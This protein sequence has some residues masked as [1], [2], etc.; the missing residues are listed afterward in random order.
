MA[1]DSIKKLIIEEI[2][3]DSV[4]LNES[5]EVIPHEDLEIPLAETAEA[6]ERLW[7]LLDGWEGRRD[8]LP[9]RNEAVGWSDV[10]R[11][12]A[13]ISECD[14]ACFDEV[15]DGRKLSEQVQRESRGPSSS[16]S[17][18]RF[19]QD[20]LKQ[21]I[22][23]VKWLNELYGYLI[24]NELSEAINRYC[25]VPS[26]R[27]FLRTLPNLHRDEDIDRE[28]KD[29][30][31]LIGESKIRCEL[32]DTTLTFLSD[33]PGKG[34]WDNEYVVGELIKRL[35]E[36]ADENPEEK[37]AKASVRL[38]AWIAGQQNW[39]LLRDFPVFSEEWD[40]KNKRTF[41]LERLPENEVRLLAPSKAWA[42]PLQPFS[43]LFPQRHILANDFFE[44][45]PS[46]EV[47][48][49]LDRE[50]F[51]KKNVII[52]KEI[53]LEEFLPNEPL[54]VDDDHQTSEDVIVTDVVFRTGDDGI[55]NRVR[56][57]RRRARIFWK[58]LTEWLVEQD[59]R[60]W[61]STKL[62]VIVGDSSLLFGRMAKTSTR[63]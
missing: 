52:T 7:L 11:S 46:P 61:R 44:T 42:A 37:F 51:C 60:A 59:P 17:H 5:G 55:M 41:K 29:I 38:F 9:R 33:E 49:E 13:T 25:I 28:L 22:S 63:L 53:N 23:G 16:V 48:Q 56:Q 26:Q 3:Q 62:S 20:S 15:I 32:R 40:S 1:R 35:R 24:D 43:E 6:V 27:G 50:G 39:D 2:R 18:L 36:Q 45:V 14:V 34:D 58:F 12:W 47:W 31:D 4:V 30:A 57:S 54:T 8:K 10:A 19:L 21:D